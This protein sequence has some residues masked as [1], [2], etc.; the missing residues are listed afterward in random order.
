MGQN[1]QVCLSKDPVGIPV[2]DD[3]EIKTSPIPNATGDQVLCRNLYLSLDPYMRGQIAGRHLSG[4]VAPGDLMRGE[5]ISEVV[6]DGGGFVAGQLI[7]CM[8]G[9]QSYSLQD[10][11]MIAVVSSEIRPSSFA[12]SVLGMTGLT[13]YAG[14]VW[15]AE[16]GK[17]DNVFIPSVTGAVGSVAAQICMTRGARVVG[18]AGGPE[19][20]LGA[21]ES[22]GV[23]ACIDRFEKNPTEKL[24]EY[25]PDGIDVYFDLV[26]GTLLGDVCQR[27]ANYGRIVLC[28]L[29][30]EYNRK[31][32]EPGPSPGL[33]IGKRAKVS[34]LV[35]YDYESRRDEFID[36]LLPLILNKTITQKE[37]VTFG[38]SN[39]PEAFCRLMR[40]EN[41]GKVIVDLTQE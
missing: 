30:A 8:G 16:V 25:F 40:G 26:G 20:C 17:G 7:R 11:T 19:K 6:K 18:M 3:F 32:R 12:L 38:L 2:A 39:A 1:M 31:E 5:T 24:G 27:L 35:V 36:S 14:M 29:M 28:G 10:P 34:G 13:A 37:D 9:W 21:L 22:I 41:Y 15:Q 23:D 4:S 33:L